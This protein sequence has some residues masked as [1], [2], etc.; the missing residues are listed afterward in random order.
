MLLPAKVMIVE[1]ELLSQRHIQN[2]LKS[3][4][5]DVVGCYDNA[6]DARAAITQGCCDMILMDI[7]IKGAEDGIQFSRSILQQYNLPIIF[8]SAYS[9]GETLEEV[10]ELSPYGF[11]TKPFS[12]KDVEVA[13]GIAYKRFHVDKEKKKPSETPAKVIQET[14]VHITPDFY[15]DIEE[16]TLFQNDVPVHLNKKQMK[17][18]ETLS[19]H[20]NQIVGYSTIIDEVWPNGVAA[21]SSLRTLVYSIRRILPDLPIESHSKLGYALRATHTQES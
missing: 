19:I 16:H 14:K 13:M 18:I 1:D 15:Y 6:A 4:D 3:L 21:D 11:I 5:V 7:N 17:L 2:I 12:A 8:I 10:M 20:C 9:D